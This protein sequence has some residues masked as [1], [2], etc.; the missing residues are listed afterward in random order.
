M[1]LRLALLVVWPRCLSYFACLWVFLLGL[2][3]CFGGLL[4]VG[5]SLYCCVLLMF[6]LRGCFAWLVIFVGLGLV[7]FGCL[8]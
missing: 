7:L 3:Y 8:C 2:F 4:I 1:C 6:G 5:V